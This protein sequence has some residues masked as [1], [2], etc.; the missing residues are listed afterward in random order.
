MQLVAAWAGFA[1]EVQGLTQRP[2][3]EVQRAFL[4][5]QSAEAREA[6]EAGKQSA[7]VAL[8]GGAVARDQPRRRRPLQPRLL[9]LLVQPIRAL[10]L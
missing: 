6:R 10:P 4:D 8:D 1:R 2:W 7:M 9:R 3:A 5:D